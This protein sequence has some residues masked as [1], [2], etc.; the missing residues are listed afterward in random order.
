[1]DEY[2]VRKEPYYNFLINCGYAYLDS[3]YMHNVFEKNNRVF[4]IVK[5]KFIFW[6]NEDNY[7]I[8]KTSLN[9]LKKYGFPVPC[10][11][12]TSYI[13]IGNQSFWAMEQEKVVGVS[14]KYCELIDVEKKDIIVFMDKI[15]QIRST[16]FGPIKSSIDS[17]Y[18][19]WREYLDVLC[20]I[21]YTTVIK[22]NMNIDIERIIMSAKCKVSCLTQG[23]FLILD[24]NVR[25]FLMK[26]NHVSGI[27]DI[28]HPIFGDPLY[29]VAVIKYFEQDMYKL[30]LEYKNYS[31]EELDI[32]KLYEIIF[33]LNDLNFR[34]SAESKYMEFFDM[35][36]DKIYAAY[37]IM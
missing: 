11:Y 19:S 16:N 17:E 30:F 18:K 34:V 12:G 31:K 27:V 20:N 1:M 26:D 5:S 32:V 15:S 10:V 3:G 37:Q 4:K 7:L 14:K 9:I 36:V 2:D 21:A 29:Q 35:Y 24:S 25:N 8:E 6:D 33:A 28:D 22:F 13:A 23:G